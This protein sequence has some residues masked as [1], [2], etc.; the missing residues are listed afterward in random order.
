M[1]ENNTPGVGYQKAKRHAMK[2]TQHML[3]EEQDNTTKRVMNAMEKMYKE[4]KVT[5]GK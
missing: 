3:R 5:K 2:E 4:K 1:Q